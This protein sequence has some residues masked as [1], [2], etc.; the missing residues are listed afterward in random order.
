MVKRDKGIEWC[1]PEEGYKVSADWKQ[2]EDHVDC[3]SE[4]GAGVLLL[5]VQKLG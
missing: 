2:D 1:P 4:Q 3:T 5:T